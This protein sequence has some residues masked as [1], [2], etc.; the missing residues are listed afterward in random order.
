MDRWL[1]FDDSVCYKKRAYNG[2]RKLIT[3]MYLTSFWSAES[4]LCFHLCKRFPD[5]FCFEKNVVERLEQSYACALPKSM[6]SKFFDEMKGIYLKTSTEPPTT[7]HGLSN[8]HIGFWFKCFSAEIFGNAQ[9][10]LSSTP[11][12]FIRRVAK[13]CLFQLKFEAWDIFE[14]VF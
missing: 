5:G 1:I 14:W 9:M 10:R 6:Y 7:F 2:K 11:Y 12:Q 3:N 8:E 4:G 13:N